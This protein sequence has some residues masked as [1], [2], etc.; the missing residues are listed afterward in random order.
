M[1]EIRNKHTPE[2]VKLTVVKVWD[3]AD[4]QDG[5]RPEK[6]TVELSNGGTEA[7][8]TAEL[9]EGNKWTAETDELPKYADGVEITYTWTEDEEGLPEGYSLT[10]T[11]LEGYVTTLTNSYTPKTVEI[12][13]RKVWNDN[14]NNSGLRPDHIDVELLANGESVKTIRIVADSD[15]EWFWTENGL[16]KYANGKEIVYTI[17]EYPIAGYEGN[18]GT[19]AET[20]PGSGV[21]TV[22]IEN[23]Q[24]TGDVAISK[25]VVSPVTAEETKAQSHR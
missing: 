16:P 2:T 9:N 20:T 12:T 19:L 7:V 17:T 15:G 4:N 3:D 18:I 13:I 10:S 11:E 25:T 14:N 6:L 23:T 8:F 21:W 5:E 22:E 1:W 24:K